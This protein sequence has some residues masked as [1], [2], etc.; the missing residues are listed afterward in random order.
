MIAAAFALATLLAS[1]L[2]D[3]LVVKGGRILPVSGPETEGSVLVENGRIVA[4]GKDVEAPYDAK[5]I[6]ATGKVVF[7]GFIEAHTTRGLDRANES[8]PITPF[9]SVA[10]S[11]DGASFAIE[12]ALREGITTIHVI[13]GNGQPIAGRGIVV[14][15][16]GRIV[17]N[18]TLVPDAALKISLLPRAGG[19]HVSQYAEIRRA[20]AEL[21]DQ[22]ERQET[23]RQD[24]DE[25]P[26]EATP[27]KTETVAPKETRAED[28]L[29]ARKRTLYDVA[30]GRAPVFVACNAA[31]VVHGIEI[32]RKHGFLAKTTFVIGAD[33]WRMADAIAA[34]G[35]PVVLDSE[36]VHRE[37]DPISGKE[38][39]TPVAPV[40]AK[41][42][43]KFALQISGGAFAQRYLNT[44][45]A[46]AVASGLDRESALK[47]ITLWPAEILGLGD[48]VGAIEKGRDGNLLIL[49]GDPLATATA[50]ETVILEGQVVYEREKDVRLKKL[51]ELR[52]PPKGEPKPTTA[53]EEGK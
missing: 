41:K 39:E 49:S 7:P 30:R 53:V 22:L 1:P 51:L 12:D 29:E 48:R 31:E 5:V 10:D 40:F 21:D 36:L 43:V 34:T 50:V 37:R 13:H 27:G 26:R 46:T 14:R 28:D 2:Q 24:D 52:E 20:F 9:L 45:A 47:S 4:V 17:E 33:A 32:A 23:K 35:R 16:V 11:L 3:R 44:Q 15:P 38:V 6:D 25:R 42:G 18:M 19:S 8:Y